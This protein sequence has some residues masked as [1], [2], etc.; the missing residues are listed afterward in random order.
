MGVQP[1]NLYL[2]NEVHVRCWDWE[3]INLM[4]PMNLH[5]HIFANAIRY[6]ICS[7][8]DNYSMSN[9]CF[10]FTSAYI[11]LSF[12][13]IWICTTQENNEMRE[14]WY[15]QISV[16]KGKIPFCT[17]VQIIS[18]E[19]PAWRDQSSIPLP[20]ARLVGKETNTEYLAYLA[21]VI[22]ATQP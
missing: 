15:K 4:F 10:F 8:G 1:L 13:T 2:T 6:K 7:I 20:N 12:S 19:L 18:T 11:I 16:E 3:K 5:F 22:W 17:I 21:T 14:Y 9:S